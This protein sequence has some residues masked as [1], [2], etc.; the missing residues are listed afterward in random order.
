[1]MKRSSKFVNF[2]Q[3]KLKLIIKWLKQNQILM[4]IFLGMRM[5]KIRRKNRNKNKEI[6]L[7]SRKCLEEMRINFWGDVL[8][9][10]PILY[11]SLINISKNG[12]ESAKKNQLNQCADSIKN[13]KDNSKHSKNR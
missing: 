7:I 3:I 10:H 9:Q 13:I 1:M 8:L 11:S 6:M 2:Q 4:M 12:S 5:I